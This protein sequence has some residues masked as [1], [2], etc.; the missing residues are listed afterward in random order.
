MSKTDSKSVTVHPYADTSISRKSYFGK[1][2]GIFRY[3]AP[4][5]W[6]CIDNP[7]HEREYDWEQYYPIGDDD[8]RSPTPNIAEGHL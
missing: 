4:V 8:D 3:I 5:G 7:Q 6:S 2:R 1:L